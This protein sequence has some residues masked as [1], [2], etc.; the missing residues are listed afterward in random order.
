MRIAQVAPLTESVPP[1]LYGGTERIVSYLTEE[2]VAAGHEVGLFASGD[3]CTAAKLFPQAPRALRFDETVLAPLTYEVRMV[4]QAARRARQFDVVHFHI[5]YLH[6]P[7][8]RRL[9]VPFVTTLHGRLDLPELAPVY[10]DFADA[11]LVSISR[12]QRGPLPH[13]NWVAAIHHGIPRNLLAPADRQ[14][15]YLAFLGR[16]APEKRPDIAIRLAIESGH[17]LK[18]AAK[19]DKVDRAYFDTVIL[20]LLAAPGIEFIGEIDDAAKSDF[21]GKAA[22]LLF[23][24]DWP[25]PFGLVLI[26]A[27]ACGTPV[28]AYDRGAVREIVEPGVTGFI[29]D[30]IADALAAIAAVPQLNR[31]RIRHEFE[32]RFTS[33]RM[34][35]DYLALYG[36]VVERNKARPVAV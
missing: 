21:L 36:A 7:V 8:F 6:L 3:S 31:S 5:D 2:L 33:Q 4:E 25:E 15:G 11:P 27:F 22:A 18:I 1:K 29:V 16:I 12:T 30:G 17:H 14:E 23:P 10:A 32:R 34:A 35:E 20:P 28:I 24:I 9:G 19:V 13:A 26:E